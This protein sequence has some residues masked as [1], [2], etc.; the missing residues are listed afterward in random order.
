MAIM[1]PVLGF[2]GVQNNNWQVGALV[3]T[4]GVRPEGTFNI[5]GTMLNATPVLIHTHGNQQVWRLDMGVPMTNEFQNISY[6]ITECERYSFSVPPLDAAP[7]MAFCSCN[8]FSSL[9]LMKDESTRDQMANWLVMKSRHEAEPYQLLLMGG[10]QVYA[11]EMWEVDGPLK[12]WA[13]L[14]FDAANVAPFTDEMDK[15][16]G[17]FYFKLYCR[18]WSQEGMK[19]MFARVPTIMMWDD[20][21]IFDGWGS[22][23][24]ERQNCPV[25]KG[26]F[27]HARKAFEVFQRQGITT[28]PDICLSPVHG[29]SLGFNLGRIGLL[30][31]DLRS[32][33]T[34]DQVMSE[35]HWNNVLGW[36]K[37]PGNELFSHLLLVSSIPIVHPSFS[38]LESFLGVFPGQQE[39]EDDLADHWNSP[40]HVGERDR[41][42]MRLLDH[43]EKTK[44]RISI[45]SGDVHVAVHG[46][47]ESARHG[48]NNAGVI[49]QFT[50]SGIVHPPPPAAALLVY[51]LLNQRQDEI[52]RGVISRM[53][54]IPG[55]QYSFIALRN[56]LSIE[57]DLD[58]ARRD[59]PRLWVHWLAVEGSVVR[60]PKNQAISPKDVK[61]Y[62]KVVNPIKET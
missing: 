16:T 32:E 59:N 17:D 36:L 45:L 43:A 22:Y 23:L 15:R 20:H 37:K 39:L 13:K 10:D 30:V 14:P 42:V 19:A 12:E 6:E 52:Q 58:E 9:K 54:A 48:D 5:G 2:Q 61:R 1:G 7:R 4:E 47:I 11:D 57:P 55:T 18:R 41:I 29:F 21:D 24:E 3:V 33:R 28:Q 44:T 53:M 27:P 25:F 49:T 26:I 56:W 8:G 38:M 31:P 51:H 35:S 50:S 62:T 40:P 60:D 34:R 46:I